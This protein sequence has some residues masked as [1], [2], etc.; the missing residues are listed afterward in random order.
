MVSDTVRDRFYVLQNSK[1]GPETTVWRTLI[2]LLHGHL[3]IRLAAVILFRRR[4]SPG[5]IQFS[6]EI[7]RV[8]IFRRRRLN[9]ADDGSTA[10]ARCPCS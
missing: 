5:R 3:Q 1:A 6:A 4:R 7:R 2:Q 9:S 8:T 10:H